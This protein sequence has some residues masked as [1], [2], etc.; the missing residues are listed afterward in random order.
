MDFDDEKLEAEQMEYMRLLWDL[1][2]SG[3]RTTLVI[4]PYTA[5]T[6]IGA[7]Q[8]VTRHVDGNPRKELRRFVD[9]LRTLFVGTPGE[10][11]VNRGDHPE[12]DK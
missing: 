3:E 9:S 4:G 11:I 1:E 7:L 8:F 6:L 2:Q 12:W 5:M 10:E